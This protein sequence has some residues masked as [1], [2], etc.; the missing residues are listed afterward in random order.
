MGYMFVAILVSN[1]E[2]EEYNKLHVN[3]KELF[4][5]LS[6]YFELKINLDNTDKS[7]FQSVRRVEPMF[8]F[9]LKKI[10]MGY[11]FVAILVSNI[12][13]LYSQLKNSYCID[14]S[15]KFPDD[16]KDV[17]SKTTQV[18]EVIYIRNCIMH[19]GG[20]FL[21]YVNYWKAQ[22]A[23]KKRNI[24]DEKRIVYEKVTKSIQDK[25]IKPVNGRETIIISK[26]DLD[27][28]FDQTSVTNISV[29]YKNHLKDLL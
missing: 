20:N 1:I 12:E 17:F 8:S 18:L 11:M 13:G 16:A 10:K 21:N 4:E 26:N 28:F 9:D 19:H 14:K 5:E 24:S 15:C 3:L 6:G 29:I 27:N 22:S 23:S 2:L 25:Y 7:N